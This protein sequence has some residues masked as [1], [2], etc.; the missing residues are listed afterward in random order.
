MN[1]YILYILSTILALSACKQMD[2]E[3][4]DFIV[5]N[6]HI[7]LQKAD[8]LKAYPGYYKLRLKWMKPK[9]PTVKYAMVYW[10]NNTDSL[11]VEWGANDDTLVVNLLELNETT[12]TFYIKNFDDQGNVSLPSEITGTPYGTN[13]LIGATDRIYISALRNT[14]GVGTINWGAKTSDLVYTEV[15]YT[16]MDGTKKIVRTNVDQDITKCPDV[17]PGELFEYRSFFSP[18][19]GID[20][21]PREWQTSEK[22]FLYKYPRTDWT[23]QARNGHHAWG[24]GGGGQPALLLDGNM[25]TGWHSTAAGAPL[26]QVVVADMKESLTMDNII[27]Y[28]P[29]QVNW[30][31]MNKVNIYI[32][33]NPLAAEEPSPS[34]GSPVASATY[35]GGDSFKITFDSPKKGR[36]M[37]IVFL[38][39]KTNTYISFMELEA[40]GY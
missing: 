8:S 20:P 21:I 9:S 40:Y 36:Y 18:R 39:S 16:S 25:S 38:D 14:E 5:P 27:I 6:G 35:T 1:R 22:P 7:Y 13:Y 17:K 29:S 24:D 4:K 26:P 19:N 10:N 11:K 37:A 31:Y 3:Y 12:Y 15:R 34:W 28:P 32:S 23:I 33:D 2:S 30:R